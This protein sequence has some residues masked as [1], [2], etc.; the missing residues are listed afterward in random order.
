MIDE[1]MQ[2]NISNYSELFHSAC[3]GISGRKC[4]Y[5][6]IVLVRKEE[7]EGFSGLIVTTN[8]NR[9][10]IDVVLEKIKKETAK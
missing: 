9:K 4:K 3:E 5:M 8:L 7:D 10:E 6:A 1:I 2:R